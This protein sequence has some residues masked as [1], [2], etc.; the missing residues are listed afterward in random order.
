MT[1]SPREINGG[2][3]RESAKERCSQRACDYNSILLLV[4]GGMLHYEFGKCKR[5]D[6]TE[7]EIANISSITSRGTACPVN[8]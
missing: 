7:K 1:I 2:T 3:L 4:D 5:V 6:A 8:R